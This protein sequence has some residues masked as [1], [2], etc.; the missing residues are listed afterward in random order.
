MAKELFSNSDLTSKIK[1][2]D[3]K[4]SVF[5]LSQKIKKMPQKAFE[6]TNGYQ[7]LKKMFEFDSLHSVN[8]AFE[9]QLTIKVKKD[10]TLHTLIITPNENNL[11]YYTLPGNVD[12]ITNSRPY[13]RGAFKYFWKKECNGVNIPVVQCMNTFSEDNRDIERHIK[14]IHALPQVERT[15]ATAKAEGKRGAELLIFPKLI[16]SPYMNTVMTAPL[17]GEPV[18]NFIK[19]KN[20]TEQS[21]EDRTESAKTIVRDIYVASNALKD[22]GYIYSDL[23]LA[24]TII[25]RTNSGDRVALIDIECITG[26]ELLERTYYYGDIIKSTLEQLTESATPLYNNYYSQYNNTIIQLK[27]IQDIL[28]NGTIESLSLIDTL[29][30]HQKSY[31]TKYISLET[32][33]QLAFAMAESPQAFLTGLMNI[34]QDN[35][36]QNQNIAVNTNA[37][38]NVKETLDWWNKAEKECINEAQSIKLRVNEANRLKCHHV[39]I[40]RYLSSLVEQ[41]KLSNVQDTNNIPHYAQQS[42]MA[43]HSD[44]ISPQDNNYTKHDIRNALLPVF[45]SPNNMAYMIQDFRNKLN[46]TENSNIADEEIT[47]LLRMICEPNNTILVIMVL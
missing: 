1:K 26:K 36:N 14:M 38:S 12:D 30:K 45:S 47:F 11:S 7:D 24:N 43:P 25:I 31:N 39:I 5:A 13:S 21:L 34:Y 46:I 15:I 22:L 19:Q 9:N 37:L 18:N 17:Y 35:I 29:S 44:I 3:S 16:N 27:L 42:G 8:C 41:S 28:N 2:A 23:K 33:P 4:I 40:Q 20:H 32:V 6:K 10:G